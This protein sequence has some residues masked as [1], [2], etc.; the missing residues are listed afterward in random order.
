MSNNKDYNWG[1]TVALNQKQEQTARKIEGELQGFSYQE[2][3][4]IFR[5]LSEM[6]SNKAII[7]S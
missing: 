5:A 6:L 1:L 4:D 3:L 2:A 7:K